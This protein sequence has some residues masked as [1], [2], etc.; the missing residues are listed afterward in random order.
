MCVKQKMFNSSAFSIMNR[1]HK[2]I[3]NKYTKNCNK[4]YSRPMLQPVKEEKEKRGRAC[5]GEKRGLA[6]SQPPLHLSLTDLLP[7]H[8][9]FLRTHF[10]VSLLPALLEHSLS[11]CVPPSPMLSLTLTLKHLEKTERWLS[12]PLHSLVF[13]PNFPFLISPSFFLLL[14]LI[15][16]VIYIYLHG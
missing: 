14:F 5:R 1:K 6:G 13:L 2:T 11:F 15:I 3:V 8:H 7:S 16:K 9:A 4:N 12:D 10:F